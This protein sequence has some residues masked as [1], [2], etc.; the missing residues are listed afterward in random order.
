M[1]PGR[2]LRCGLVGRAG[3]ALAL[4]AG[5]GL[6][7]SAAG[8]GGSTDARPRP[9][10]G[11]NAPSIRERPLRVEV[12]HRVEQSA[13]EPHRV[14]TALERLE[15]PPLRR[16]TEVVHYVR[17]WRPDAFPKQPDSAKAKLFSPMLDSA[18]AA[19]LLARHYHLATRH[20][21]GFAPGDVAKRDGELHQDDTLALLALAG[22]PA[23]TPVTVNG[24]P[25]TVAGVVRAAM[26]NAYL[27]QPEMAWTATALALYV[28]PPRDWENKFGQRL[29]LDACCRRLCESQPGEGACGGAHVLFALAV[30]L[31]ADAQEPS[32]SDET[33]R[34]VHARLEEAARLLTA[35]QHP[36]GSWDGGWASV[37]PTGSSGERDITRVIVTSHSL[38]WLAVAP[39]N[40]T[41]DKDR[42][43]AACGY[44]ARELLDAPSDVLRREWCAYSHAGH[45]LRWWCPEGWALA[46]SHW[47]L[48]AT[49]ELAAA[50]RDAVAQT[51]GGA[52]T[53]G[54][55]PALPR[56]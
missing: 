21:V 7:V 47:R 39:A 24:E 54:A 43:R 9:A 33:R 46:E 4:L 19:A 42:V 8:C 25:R 20:G 34:A 23:D 5:V 31:Q 36:D 56:P 49:L 41:M 18:T 14:A 40:V 52:Q 22:A 15:E 44:L 12:S 48:P 51:H 1:R 3:A 28:P 27:S 37:S 17:L 6:Q 55:A 53:T 2:C 32:L 50:K 29:S 30:M 38:E 45:A 11:P 10:I 16:W 13:L 26:A 35:T